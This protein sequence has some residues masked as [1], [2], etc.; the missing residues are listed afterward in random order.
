MNNQANNNSVNVN[1]NIDG[2][3]LEVEAIE[4][5]KNLNSSQKI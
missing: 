2:E 1:L 3:V 5:G 4:T